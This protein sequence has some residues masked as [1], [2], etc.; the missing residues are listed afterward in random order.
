MAPLGWHVQ[1]YA[2]AELL[3][4]VV[5]RLLALPTPVVIDHLGQIDPAAG[6]RQPGFL[7]M[8]RLLESGRGWIKLCAYRSDLSGPPFVRAAPFV[9]ALAAAAPE[10]L[11]WGTDWPHPNLP[12]RAPG[13][14][15]PMPDDGDLLDAL[16]FWF[17]DREALSRILV[18][19]PARLY[20]FGE[21][22]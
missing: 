4:D 14:P 5:T 13:V 8:L 6:E 16:G 3:A 9:R 17:E 19:N 2:S 11:V 12:E 18:A 21:R 15:M 7:A 1:I 20:G 22:S 10:R